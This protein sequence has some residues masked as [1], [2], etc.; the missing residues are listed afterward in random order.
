M[1]QMCDKCK[2]E[3]KPS[4]A[5]NGGYYRAHV[6]REDGAACDFDFCRDCWDKFV[7]SFK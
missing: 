3:C 6:V 5:T 4:I 2:K 7:W 1:K